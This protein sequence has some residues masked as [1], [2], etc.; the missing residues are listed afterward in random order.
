MPGHSGNVDIAE[1]LAIRRV[2]ELSVN[3]FNVYS[4]LVSSI[5]GLI[6]LISL[7]VKSD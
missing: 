5:F 2:A 1:P 6:V 7:L 3:S 4:P